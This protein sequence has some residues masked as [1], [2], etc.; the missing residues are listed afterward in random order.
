MLGTAGW[1]VPLSC[2]ERM[3]GEGSHLERYARMLKA[4]EINTSFYR[5]HRF[6]TYERWAAVTPDDFRFA[7]KVP[8]L[9]THETA[10]NSEA[11]Y[12]FCEEIAGLGR[13]LSVLL[14]QFPPSRPFDDKAAGTLFDV[15]QR[16]A[17]ANLVCE[18]R[19]AT[20]FTHK[21]DL[22]LNARRIARVAADPPRVAEADRPGGWPGLRYIRLHGSPRIY[23]SSYE[24]EFL[25]GLEKR[26]RDW[27]AT[28]DVWCIFDNTAAG[29]AMENA[30]ALK[31]LDNAAR[32][33]ATRFL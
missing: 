22:W 11:I 28:D 2:R 33:R 29:A 27:L 12:R 32:S 17:A 10:F 13:K 20:W 23:Y 16:T 1:N 9:I 7:V 25:Q 8:Q 4:V 5:P 3:G 19:H 24:A 6:K 15:L 30:L 31:E 26:L 14:V 18:P 21:V